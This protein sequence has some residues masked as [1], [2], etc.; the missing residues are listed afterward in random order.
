[1]VWK[2]VNM[3]LKKTV[4]EVKKTR[5]VSVVNMKMKTKKTKKTR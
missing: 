4:D 2:I 1:M 3:V 5:A